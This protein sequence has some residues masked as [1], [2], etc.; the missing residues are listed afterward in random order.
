MHGLG[1]SH[2]LLNTTIF[3]YNQ[4]IKMLSSVTKQSKSTGKG[5]SHFICDDWLHFDKFQEWLAIELATTPKDHTFLITHGCLYNDYIY[6][7]KTTTVCTPSILHPLMIDEIG[8]RLTPPSI[9]ITGANKDRYSLKFGKNQ[10]FC[11][12]IKRATYDTLLKAHQTIC[13]LKIDRFNK[14]ID[15]ID[16][17]ILISIIKQAIVLLKYS[18]NHTE[19][20]IV[21]NVILYDY[22]VQGLID[23]V[24]DNNSVRVDSI[25]DPLAINGLRVV[26]VAK[27]GTGIKLTVVKVLMFDS[28][29]D[30]NVWR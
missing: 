5:T 22:T 8:F 11:K 2:K 7:P 21:P 25:L 4:W 13:H 10:G 1:K 9:T 24:Y 15:T 29:V 27:S 16:N 19:S 14:V 26:D 6:T 28:N 20:L 30:Y 12:G 23:H 3:G 17:P 18:C